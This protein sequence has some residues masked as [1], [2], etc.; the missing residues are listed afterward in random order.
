MKEE[1]LAIDAVKHLNDANL[2]INSLSKIVSQSSNS[3]KVCKIVDTHFYM[4]LIISNYSNTSIITPAG[5]FSSK[6][7]LFVGFLVPRKCTIV[8]NSWLDS[9]SITTGSSVGSPLHLSLCFPY[10]YF[11]SSSTPQL[12]M[13]VTTVIPNGE[14][15]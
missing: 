10:F 1:K 8:L 2:Q 12:H 6:P 14:R 11:I 7:L 4:K 5:V 13:V 15:C 9:V 3:N